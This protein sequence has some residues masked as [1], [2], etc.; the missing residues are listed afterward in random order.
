MSLAET[1]TNDLM[2][3]LARAVAPYLVLAL[4]VFAAYSN[5]FDN[6]FL[7]DDDLIIKGNTYLKGWDHI[8]D[9][10]TGSTTSGMHIVGGF[11]RP[12]QI[13]LYLLAYHL[14]ENPA[15]LPGNPSA[16]TYLST[17][18]FHALN[19]GLHIANTCFVYRLGTKLGFNAKG[20]FL[21][22]LVWGV[23]PL[24]TEAVT[25]MSST[26]DT[27]HTF[28]CLLGVVVLLP[29]ITPRKIF[30][31]IPLFLLGITSKETTAMF[32]LLVMV[33]LFAT[34]PQRFS[35]R[36]YFRTWPLWIISLVYVYWRA[37]AQGF[38]GPQ[39]YDRFYKM[40][41]FSA[42]KTYSEQ[43]L[44]RLYTFLATLPEY[45]KLLVWPTH[46]H[47]ERTF[48]IQ[49]HPGNWLVATG[50]LM[51]VLSLSHIAYSYN[52]KR[53]TALSWG[54]LWFG[55]AHAPDT[56]LLVPM[57][58]LFLEHWMY[59]PTA[60][61]FLGLGQTLVDLTKGLSKTRVAVCSIAL[62]FALALSI[63]TYNQNEIWRDPPSFY[64]NIFANGENSARARNNLALYYSDQGKYDEAIDQFNK[65]I[66]AS[67]IYA[68]TRYNLAILYWQRDRDM[69][70]TIENLERSLQIQPNFYRASK[71][72]GDIYNAMND[73]EKAGFYYAQE[74]KAFN[75]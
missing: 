5:T 27:L 50:F 28:F 65:A 26:A 25:Y 41:I 44:Y 30:M 52:I 34:N 62:G 29:D 22:A 75:E 54:L 42:L 59:L 46:L 37:H 39:T 35:P 8:W 17:F 16:C 40:P 64:N 70:K 69:D 18:W 58:S 72:L 47:M 68:E 73:K 49:E 55:A 51:I 10:L 74:K 14:G 38:D 63:K 60:G 32:P 33:C 23:H 66:E 21:A 61:L 56:G 11:Y 1:Q 7:F 43:P 20:V 6:V 48:S 57:N 24:H 4:V 45:T 15:C 53:W 9:I 31:V 67:D 36:T 3:P 2:P 12:L 71:A 19:L 13:L